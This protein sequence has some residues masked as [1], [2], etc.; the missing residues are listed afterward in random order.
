MLSDHCGF[1]VTSTWDDV[2]L[3]DLYR[4]CVYCI[5][6]VDGMRARITFGRRPERLEE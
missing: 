3:P 5:G 4:Y 1:L 2:N 6:T